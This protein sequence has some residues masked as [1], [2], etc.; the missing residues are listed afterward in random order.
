MIKKIKSSKIIEKY[1]KNKDL[2][3]FLMEKAN[4]KLD[5]KCLLIVYKYNQ[6][7]IGSILNSE[8]NVLGDDQFILDYITEIRMFSEYGEIHLWKYGDAFKWRL[9]IDEEVEGDTNIY[10]EEHFIWGTKVNY[11][12]LVEEHRGMKIRFP[13]DISN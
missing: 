5:G 11:D 13:S 6:V 1:E 2:K 8:L 3:Q 10:E 9:R 4:K 7:Y 12:E